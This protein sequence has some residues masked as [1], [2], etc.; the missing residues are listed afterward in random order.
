MGSIIDLK[1]CIFG[2]WTVLGRSD[3]K[4][5]NKSVVW[6]CICTC[7]RIFDVNGNSL[8]TIA[9]TKCVRCANPDR[10]T[11]YTKDPIK[12]IYR[13]MKQRC[14]YEGHIKYNY[15]GGRG[16]GICKEW[17][18]NPSSFY[19]WS[20]RNGY[21]KGLSIER[22]NNDEGYNPENCKFITLS[23]Q[24]N[25]KRSSIKIIIN[26]ETKILSEWCKIYNIS[27]STVDRR[28]KSGMT[29]EEALK[30]PTK[31]QLKEVDY[32]KNSIE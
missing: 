6:S 11:K 26:N 8:R 1:G 25:N 7:G 10:K 12:I 13:G 23:E 18:D 22:I 24:Q 5:K 16:I 9:S 15:Y 2:E 20:Y 19:E 3:K 21:K 32:D 4:A 14:Y 31:T 28:V 29:Y 27:R 30:K 17:L